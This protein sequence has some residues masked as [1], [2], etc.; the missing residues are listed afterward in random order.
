MDIQEKEEP[1]R[2]GKIRWPWWWYYDDPFYKIPEEYF[3][4]FEAVRPKIK[5]GENRLGR[6]MVF[7]TM[8]EDAENLKEMF[9]NPQTYNLI[10]YTMDN[11]EELKRMADLNT[12][13]KE[14]LMKQL[15]KEESLEVVPLPSEVKGINNPAWNPAQQTE[16]QFKA[17]LAE[18]VKE[19][20]ETDSEYHA[21]MGTGIEIKN[22]TL[23]YHLGELN[24]EHINHFIK[25]GTIVT[26]DISDGYHTFGEL[27]EHR[28]TLFIALCT[29][30]DGAYTH[31]HRV[32]AGDKMQHNTNSPVWK[33]R[34]HSDGSSWDGWFL[35]GIYKEKEKQITYHLPI[36][37]WVEC[38]FIE[39]DKAPEWDG[40]TS[41]DVLERL[42]RL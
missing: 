25:E 7:G 32:M 2:G 28:I 20:A 30:I 4:M 21:L 38:N 18:G 39:L 11:P 27:Y 13:N 19:N 33:T 22:P 26:N 34:I 42:K 23:T 12:V 8:G 14:A 5:E 6:I 10:P 36:S 40:H 29:I 35:L 24:A 41:E 15:M 37:K 9:Y 3:K 17:M 1:V 16:E 31:Y